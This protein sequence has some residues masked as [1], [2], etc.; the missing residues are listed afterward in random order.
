MITFCFQ[1]NVIYDRLKEKDNDLSKNTLD[2]LELFARNG[3]LAKIY[4][5]D[6]ENDFKDSNAG[7]LLFMSKFHA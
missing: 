2:H 5:S 6:F 7:Q 4:D 3:K 1:D